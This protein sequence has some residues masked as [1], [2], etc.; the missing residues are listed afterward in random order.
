MIAVAVAG[1]SS[2]G[3]FTQ[4]EFQATGIRT[5]AIAPVT[6]PVPNEGARQG[7]ANIFADGLRARG[8]RVVS[9]AE[10]AAGEPSTLSGPGNPEGV[11]SP[12]STQ[13]LEGTENPPQ[14]DNSTPKGAGEP[15][16]LSGPG[17]PEG[18]PSPSSTQTLEGSGNPPQYNNSTGEGAGEPSTLTAPANPAGVAS[19]SSTQTLEGTEN[20]P[21]YSNYGADATMRVNTIQWSQEV[22]MTASLVDNRT[23]QTVWSGSGNGNTEKLWVTLGSA[24]AGALGGAAIGG[25][26]HAVAG[27]VVGGAAGGAGG[28][29][30]SPKEEYVAKHIAEKMLATLPN[31]Q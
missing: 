28:Y 14:Y 21:Q 10:G 7:V 31:A 6:G 20:P 1:C 22:A 15:S 26:E 4:P 8:Y 25:H 12:S 16:A 3:G 11:V 9:M 29:F 27:A 5:V 13:T 18:V 23:G 30:L 2:G 19:P 24:A 17:N